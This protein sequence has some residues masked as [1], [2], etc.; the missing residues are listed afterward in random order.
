MEYRRLGLTDLCVSAVGFGAWPISGMSSVG[1]N[2][3]DSLA[4]IAACLDAGV[5]FFD[6]AYGYGEQGESERLLARALG[7][8]RDEVVL[9]TKGGIE[10]GPGRQQVL[11]GSPAKLRRQ[12]E[13]SLERLETD[14]VDLLYL[15]APDPRTPVAESAAELARLMQEGKARAIGASNCTVEQLAEF[16][17]ACPLAAVQPA[18]NMLQR[19]IEQDLVPWCVAQGVAIVVYWPLLKGLLAGKL[20]R[21]HVFAAGDGRAKYPMF[22]GAEWQKNQDFVDELRP[23]AA[24]AG[25]SVAQLVIN[26]T[27]HQPGITS[28][29]C[30]AKRPDQ[31]HENAGGAAAPL[32]DALRAK[33]DAALAQRGTP[34]VR[35]PV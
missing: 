35:L 16:A 10:W 15:H 11:D 17:S 31:A 1:V 7:S 20:A 13:T 30:G 3:A 29:L 25:L 14:C 12:C 18:Y 21:D 22:Q 6:T 23:I 9:A 8:R 2:D 5:N 27:V 28:A 33:I 19:D 26:W 24:E 32:S 4:T 34:Q